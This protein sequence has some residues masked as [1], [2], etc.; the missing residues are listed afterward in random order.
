MLM[1]LSKLYTLV[2]GF[3]LLSN[4]KVSAQVLAGHGHEEVRGEMNFTD[5][6]NY[7]LA[8]PEPHVVKEPENDEDEDSR[9]HHSAAHDPH[10][11]HY[12][13]TPPYAPPHGAFGPPSLPVSPAPTDTFEAVIDPGTVIPPDTH[14]AV[15]S[16]YCITAINSNVRIQTRAGVTVSTVSLDGFWS[17]I[18]GAGSYDP[19]IHYDATINRWVFVTDW[20]AESA[21]SSILI[22]VSK[23]SNPTGAWW[24]YKVLT[25]PSAREWLD[26]PE[27]GF[28]GKWLVVTGNMFTVAAN[29]YDSAKIFVFNMANLASGVG[30][31]YTVFRQQNSFAIAP[32]ITYDAAEQNEYMVESWDGTATGG[33]QMQLWQISGAVGSEAMT[34][35]GFPASA[36][37][38]WQGQSNAVSGTGGADFV[39]QL[40]TANLIQAN[41]DRV[42]QV[43]QMNSKLWF[44]HEVFLP[45]STSTNPTRVSVQWWQID[46]LGVPAQIGLIDDPSAAN[47]NFYTFPTIAV[48]NTNDALIGFSVTSKLIHPCAAYTLHMHTDAV[49]SMRPAFIY[50][51][52]QNTYFK[53]FGSTRDRW[54]DYSGTVLDPRTGN[55]FWTI[56]ECSAAATNTWDTWW[57]YVK[58]CVP[59]VA[60]ITPAGPTS[61]CSPATVVLNANT[62]AGLTYQWEQGG[63]AIAG[64]TTS[65]YTATVT[66]TYNVIVYNSATCD[67]VSLPVVV[68]VNPVPSAILGTL[69]MC[70]GSGTSLSDA[71]A[72]GTWSS[73]TTAVATIATSGAVTGVTAGTSI[74]SYTIATGCAATAVVT[75]NALP[76]A[77]ITPAGP[78][79]FCTGGSVVLNANTGAGFTYQWQLGGGN[80]AG[81]TLSSYTATLGGN[82]TVI[83][84]G[85]GC[86]STS[87]ITTITVGTPPGA[88]I[89]PA[90]PTTFCTGGSVV[91]NANTGAGYTYQWQL[92]GGNIAGATTSSYT[93]TLAGNYTV[94]VYSNGCN[95][96]SSI[97]TVTITAGPGATITPAGPTTFCPGGSVVLDANTGAGI[98]YQ[99]LLGGVNIPG[100]TLS[101]YTATAAGNYAVIV[102]SGACVVTSATTTVNVL[103]LPTVTPIG[104]TNNICVGGVTT[105]TDATSGGAWSSSDATVASV[106]GSGDVTGITA[107]TAMITYTESNTCGSVTAT[108]DM[109]VNA[110]SSVAAITGNT[111]IC[112]GQTSPLSDITTGGVWSSATPAVATVSAGGLVTGISIGSDNISYTVTNA[113]GCVSSAVITVNIVAAL[114]ASITHASSTT[115]CTGGF[116]VL[117]ATAGVGY[118]YQW[119][120]GGVNIAGATSAA[121]T[122]TTSG[123]YTVIITNATGC[124]GTSSGVVVTV[125][126]SPIVVPSVNI[127]ASLGTVLCATT[128]PETFTA[129]PT[130]GGAGPS[131]QWYVNGTASGV[132]ATYSYTPANGDVV[133]VVLTSNDICAFPDT[134]SNSITMTISPLESP[135]VSIVMVPNHGD[136]T[137]TGD[138]VEYEAI[139]VFGGTAPIYRWTKNNIN[140]ATGP[141][142]IDHEAHDN[143]TLYVTL[144]SNYPCLAV[145]TAVSPIFILHIFNPVANALSVSV[146]QSSVVAGSVDTF[147]AVASGAGAS[148]AFQWYINGT[149]IPG[150][151]NSIYITDTLTQGE[152]VNCEETSSFVCSDPR[153]ILSGGI[154]VQVIPAGISEVGG[155][156]T[157]TLMPNPNE[158]SFTIQGVLKSQS[159]NV[160]IAVTN[161][162]GQTIFK[163]TAVAKNGKIYELVILEKSIPSGMYL[164]TVTSGESRAVFHVVIDK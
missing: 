139:P 155:L 10:L 93:A 40:G 117:N 42:T 95:S 143:D 20:G 69:T 152:I 144:Q 94:I 48:N 59:P 15:D 141:Y 38:N 104:G 21:T 74:I 88:T 46:T 12:R 100:V 26:Y 9:P 101:S 91:L 118:T 65:S 51:H 44:A 34:S 110:A 92:G 68:S 81:A 151:T 4:L 147:T 107:G 135:S 58:V 127:S 19:R 126:P 161:M 82:Y 28:N 18:V 7:F 67:S 102:S 17:S 122:A 162:L 60:T 75:V 145:D 22:A 30:A 43:I 160:N 83:V 131:Y 150:A 106:D 57:A 132:G 142:F 112:V 45:Y 5:L 37:F 128:S 119:Q 86:S 149:P 66:G 14:G 29:A 130:Y 76:G 25:D 129:V 156:N 99:W 115:F 3:F 138:T 89:T 120:V 6:A 31:S 24:M 70:A 158:G 164:V 148:P 113:S 108:F 114:T 2:I 16:N 62:G 49:D 133:K 1:R 116:V 80:I 96:T 27:V 39:P 134:A 153:T 124:S 109:T 41:D 121:Y 56:Q 85:G 72:G 87:A 63:T 154:S 111:S 140:V 53:N 55:D 54:G 32:A 13:T 36:G 61:V 50:R 73:V 71:T 35:V 163:K 159:D 103:S 98:T 146:S 47:N 125:N 33:G 11:I 8:H 78:T 79:T 90:G 23:T 137:C 157:F 123:N 105:L 84:N 52:G 136:S 97:T 77:T 64:A